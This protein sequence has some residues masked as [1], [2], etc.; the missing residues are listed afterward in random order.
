[1]QK[2]A[3]LLLIKSLERFSTKNWTKMG[4]SHVAKATFFLKIRRTLSNNPKNVLQTQHIVKP[5]KL[6]FFDF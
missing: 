2:N 4:S 5:P 3:K 6:A 1:M